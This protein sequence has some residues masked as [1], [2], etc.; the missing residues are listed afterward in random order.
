MGLTTTTPG[1]GD[2]GTTA[3]PPSIFLNPELWAI[4]LGSPAAAGNGMGRFW[5]MDPSTDERIM[6]NFVRPSSWADVTAYDVDVYWGPNGTGGG[7]V[8]WTWQHKELVA[9]ATMGTLITVVTA[10]AGAAGTTTQTIATDGGPQRIATSVPIT[11][12]LHMLGLG[13][14]ADNA[15]DTLA[16]D[17]WVFGVVLTPVPS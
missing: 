5:A 13:R 1:G 17:A 9:G 8:I 10:A 16:H 12:N 6:C 11:G 2:S 3:E 7:N 4:S 15:S 14:D